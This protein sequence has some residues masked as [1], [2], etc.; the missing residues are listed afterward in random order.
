[1]KIKALTLYQPWATMV[2]IGAKMIETRSWPTDYKGTLAIHAGKNRRYLSR[3]GD[4]FMAQQLLAQLLP[5]QKAKFPATWLQPYPLG[6]IVA[7]CELVHCRQ[8]DRYDWMGQQRGWLAG[9]KFW[10]ATNQEKML[11][12]YTPG[13]YMWFLDN[14]RI[15]EQPITCK[16]YQGLWDWDCPLTFS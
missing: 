13:R 14:I 15:F 10:P 4:Q 16:G 6:A 9:Q 7:I 12:D 2:A 1:M 5:E 8:V 11:G 3:I